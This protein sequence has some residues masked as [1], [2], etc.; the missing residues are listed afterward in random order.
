MCAPSKYFASPIIFTIRM[1]RV[2]R[3]L[4]SNHAKIGASIWRS[5]DIWRSA[6]AVVG[7]YRRRF[8]HHCRRLGFI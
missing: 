8:S 2:T 3:Q 6:E 4:I 5:A 7:G 1:R